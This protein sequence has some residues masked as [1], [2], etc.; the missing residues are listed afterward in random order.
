MLEICSAALSRPFRI[1][2]K[3]PPRQGS[4]LLIGIIHSQSKPF[5]MIFLHIYKNKSFAMISL[6]KNRGWGVKYLPK[7]LNLD[8]CCDGLRGTRTPACALWQSPRGLWLSPAECALT[9]LQNLK[10]L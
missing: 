4:S 1:A 6:R 2:P 8:Q 9:N 10:H 7:T 3:S 5:R